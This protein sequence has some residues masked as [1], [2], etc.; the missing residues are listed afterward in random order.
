MTADNPRTR[1]ELLAAARKMAERYHA[2]G[3]D[4]SPRAVEGTLRVGTSLASDLYNATYHLAPER[5]PIR[6]L[7]APQRSL[8]EKLQGGGKLV[9]RDGKMWLVP[10]GQ[11]WAA[12]RRVSIVV[13]NNLVGQ[14]LIHPA[15]PLTEAGTKAL[16]AR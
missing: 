10:A 5:V 2:K 15:G 16:K 11:P 14:K 3:W 4:Y 9:R 12:R 13:Y 7:T 6:L 1:D 8:L